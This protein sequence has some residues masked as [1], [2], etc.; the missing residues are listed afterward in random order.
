MV[1]CYI[2][3]ALLLVH[4]NNPHWQNR[5]NDPIGSLLGSTPF[6]SMT[7]AVTTGYF[8]WDFFVCVKHFHLFGIGFLFHAVAAMFAFTC[9]FIPYCQPWAGA[10]LT[11]ELSTPFVN[12]NWFA[13]HLPAGTFSEKYI[14]I[15]GLLL[16][17][18]FFAARIVWGFYAVSQ[19]AVDMLA[20]LDRVNK[21]IPLTI[22]SMNLFLNML[23]LFWFYKMVRIAMK[24]ASGGKSTRQAAKEAEKIE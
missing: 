12:I 24:K 18:V 21:L 16:M 8:V 15:N 6:G 23:N 1:Q 3:I 7:C 4:L 22:L 2:S 10:F 9:G 5:K 17:F 14:V 20:S 13:S 19:M 11:F